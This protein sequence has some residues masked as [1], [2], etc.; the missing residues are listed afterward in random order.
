M[1]EEEGWRE[2]INKR[3]EGGRPGRQGARGPGA[4]AP[5]VHEASGSQGARK[6]R[7]HGARAPRGQEARGPGGQGASQ[8]GHQN[9]SKTRTLK[10]KVGR[11]RVPLGRKSTSKTSKPL[12]IWDTKMRQKRVPLNKKCV[13]HA[14][15]SSKS[16]S[17]LSIFKGGQKRLPLGKKCVKNVYP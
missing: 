14:Y 10:Q 13:K 12:I 8:L 6:P 3:K 5:G 16:R 9:A 7:S 2:G 15:P 4:R 17:E 11:K 1:R